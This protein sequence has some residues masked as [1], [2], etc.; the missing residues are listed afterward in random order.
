[1]TEDEKVILE[2]LKD[3]DEKEI[4]RSRRIHIVRS[5]AHYMKGFWKEVYWAWFL[6]FCEVGCEVL[7]P[8]FSKYLVNE[9]DQ[10]A[11]GGSP[12]N[13]GALWLWGGF[14]GLGSQ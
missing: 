12:I 10:A 8:F 4:S 3:R 7:I 5:L 9:I 14:C 6:V 11:T 2:Q 1:M 13:V